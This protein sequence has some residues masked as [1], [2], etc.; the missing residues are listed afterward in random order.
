MTAENLL[1]LLQMVCFSKGTNSLS[2]DIVNPAVRTSCQLCPMCCFWKTAPLEQTHKAMKP[3]E[4]W[5]NNV[6]ML[7]A[8]MRL[9]Q[10]GHVAGTPSPHMSFP[11]TW[12]WGFITVTHNPNL[13]CQHF[14]QF[15]PT[16]DPPTPFGIGKYDGYFW[17]ALEFT[18]QSDLFKTLLG[19]I[20]IQRITNPWLVSGEGIK[21]IVLCL[22]CFTVLVFRSSF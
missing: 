22:V 21:Y 12:Q 18:Y 2:T 8:I 10:G 13:P 7:K 19:N 17:T 20:E 11:C 9:H 14:F 15:E 6:H 3:D 5:S 1:K 16:F 4:P